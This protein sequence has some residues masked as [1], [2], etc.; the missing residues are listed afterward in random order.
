MV[1]GAKKSR[2]ARKVYK[3]VTKGVKTSY[4]IRKP[5]GTVCGNCGISL[6]GISA[7][8]ASAMKNTAK[9][10]KRAQRPFGGVL[11]SSCLKDLIVIEARENNQ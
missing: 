5:S 11:C 7:K 9:S 4:E 1:N 6:P 10:H 2:S 8:K 3:R